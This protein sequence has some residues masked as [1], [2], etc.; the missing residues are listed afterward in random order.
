MELFM[1]ESTVFAGMKWLTNMATLPAMSVTTLGRIFSQAV[2]DQ[3]EIQDL[4]RGDEV[5]DSWNQLD[6]DYMAGFKHTANSLVDMTHAPV[7]AVVMGSL[8]IAESDLL[9][10]RV[11]P[12]VGW[13]IEDYLDLDLLRMAPG[14]TDMFLYE[15]L[16]ARGTMTEEQARDLANVKRDRYYLPAGSVSFVFNNSPLGELNRAM[17]TSQAMPLED[18]MGL[19]PQMA[20]TKVLR[21]VT[22]FETG[23]TRPFRQASVEEPKSTI[24]TP[25]V[26]DK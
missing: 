24:P 13:M 15:D 18:A 4:Q 11:H 25:N 19:Q 20:A 23:E 16:V 1:P 3:G 21:G 26:S 6:P 8:E 14:E 7:P 17:L 9:P 2:A 22:G 5:P 12:A 10:T